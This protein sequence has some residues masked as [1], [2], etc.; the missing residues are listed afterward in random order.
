MKANSQFK[1]Q[2]L[3]VVSGRREDDPRALIITALDSFNYALEEEQSILMADRYIGLFLLALDPAHIDG[4][5]RELRKVL[6][7]VNLDVAMEAL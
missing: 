6:A 7:G 5:E 1:G 3:L 4:M 2:A